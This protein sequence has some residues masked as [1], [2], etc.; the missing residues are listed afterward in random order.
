MPSGVSWDV[1]ELPPDGDYWGQELMALGS[2]PGDFPCG[3][4]CWIPRDPGGGEGGSRLV[5][6]HG[7]AGMV[8]PDLLTKIHSPAPGILPLTAPKP[9]RPRE[10]HPKAANTF[11]NGA[12]SRTFGLRFVPGTELNVFTPAKLPFPQQTGRDL[13][14]SG[15]PRAAVAVGYRPRPLLCP[16]PEFRVQL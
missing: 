3:R 15:P 13:S 2:V 8:F 12:K 9:C 7:E 16:H 4:K 6:A 11:Q 14:A 10:S 5:G 1:S